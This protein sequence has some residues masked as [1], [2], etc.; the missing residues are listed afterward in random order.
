MASVDH[1]MRIWNLSVSLIPRLGQPFR[2]V[3]LSTSCIPSAH[4]VPA[5]LLCADVELGH[6]A[7]TEATSVMRL[8]RAC[9]GRCMV[10]S[11]STYA[12]RA[13]QYRVGVRRRTPRGQF[14]GERP[15]RSLPGGACGA[16]MRA[17]GP[18]HRV[19]RRLRA[20]RQSPRLPRRVRRRIRLHGL[21][22]HRLLV[23]VTHRH[24]RERK[25]EW[26]YG[27]G[28]PKEAETTA[29]AE[30]DRSA[31]RAERCNRPIL[32]QNYGP[33]ISRAAERRP[34]EGKTEKQSNHPQQ[35]PGAY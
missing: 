30:M 8:L 16:D 33:A 35:S 32:L 14:G 23:I 1:T 31:T 25:R 20:R 18:V 21:L 12:M 4:L 13:L 22:L 11:K 34:E 24:R 26:K 6:D 2:L 5:F 29:R 7:T 19:C 15:M 27:R 3:L 9:R 28:R 17:S 10:Q